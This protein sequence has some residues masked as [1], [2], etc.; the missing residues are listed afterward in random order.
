MNIKVILI[1]PSYLSSLVVIGKDGTGIPVSSNGEDDEHR[2]VYDII[3]WMD[4]RAVAEAEE[5]NRLV[6]ERTV[7]EKAEDGRG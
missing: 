7:E 5:I 3:V 6:G 1:L 2:R 4:H